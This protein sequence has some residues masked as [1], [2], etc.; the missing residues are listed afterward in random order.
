M[1]NDFFPEGGI[2]PQ[3]VKCPPKNGFRGGVKFDV[4][5]G[6]RVGTI[7]SPHN[8]GPKN[9]L[10]FCPFWHFFS[11]NLSKMPGFFALEGEE[12]SN[13]FFESGHSIFAGSPLL[14]FPMCVT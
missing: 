1:G 7:F 8:W 4:T 11:T 10:L 3:K 2:M 14:P 5:E 6:E 12:E 13:V 9:S